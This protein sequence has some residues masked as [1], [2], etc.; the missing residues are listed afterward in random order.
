[1]LQI[2]IPSSSKCIATQILV[3]IKLNEGKDLV[4]GGCVYDM[5][6]PSKELPI[7]S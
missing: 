2:L 5:T 1:M 6:C 3:I 4:L 7:D